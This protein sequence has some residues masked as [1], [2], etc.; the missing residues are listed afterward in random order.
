[1]PL[2]AKLQ[3][4]AG[5]L[6]IDQ[7]FTVAV[8]GARDARLDAGVPRFLDQLSRQ[9]G[10]P[11]NKQLV[12]SAKAT[13]VI[14]S[15]SAGRAVQELGEDESYSLEVTA[16]RAT[17]NAPNPLGALHGLQ[18]FLQLVA[19]TPS[20][21]AVPV[22]SIQDQPRFAWRGLLIDVSRHFFPIEVLKRNLEGMAAVKLNVL[23]WHLS[24]DEGFRV[25]SKKFP[26]L[27]ELGSQ[28]DYY[29][30]AEIRD[31]LAYARERGIRVVPEFD[32]PGHSRSWVA[33]Y[34]ELASTPG[35]FEAGRI[36][37]ADTV[38]DPTRD[39]TYKFLDKLIAEM[40]G[41]FPDAYFHIG[42]DEVNNKP[43]DSNPKIQEFIHAHGMKDNQD[44]QEYFNQRLEKIVSKH[45]KIMMGW[46]E[47]LH[48]DLP[49]PVV[50]H[51]WRGQESL[52]AAARAG[53]GTLLSYGYYLDLMWPAA[54]HYAVDPMSGDAATLTPEESKHILGGEACMWA[55][56][57]TPETIDS[58]IWP[59]MAAVAE[60]LWSPQNATDP[61]S[62]Y[63]RLDQMS[64]RLGWLGLTHDSNY[65]P[66][67]RRLAGGDDIRALRV[68][69]DAVEPTK[70]YTRSEVWPEPPVKRVPLNRLVDVAR[71]ESSTVRHFSE[72]VEAYAQSGYKDSVIEAQ[73]RSW[74]VKWQGNHATLKP[75]LEQSFLLTEALPLSE[76]L[77][78][79]SSAGLQ[80]LDAIKSNQPLPESW[81][82][83]QLA[84]VDRSMKPRA[85][86]LIMVA[87]SIQK[88]IE[89]ASP[90]TSKP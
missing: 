61:K 70:D 45:G 49:K 16:T 52:A 48:P 55:E 10:M 32:M 27:Q 57:I 6:V 81:R 67:L 65:V 39:E 22:V 13:L 2:P 66:M 87:P 78:T 74:L 17:L 31:F 84:V 28:G 25:E 68:L 42:G 71:P 72:I 47:I 23:H 79:L 46:D 69:A 26:K 85:N 40:A 60:R 21:F 59:R 33:A 19:T 58:R 1:M 89:A 35:P 36:Q 18:T 34:P 62:M 86:L 9:T 82:A 5:Q 63:E 83:E 80:S 44:L 11:L 90:Q 41:L 12:D 7:L 88:L 20:G 76:D 50:V 14:H 30:Q 3:P 8:T 77:A 29:T 75:V 64:V 73:I 43:W 4:G 56:Y 15:D 51:S 53:H 24:D 37:D 38:I 54:R